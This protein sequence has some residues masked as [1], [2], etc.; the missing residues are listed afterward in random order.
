MVWRWRLRQWHHVVL[1]VLHWLQRYQLGNHPQHYTVHSSHLHGSSDTQR[2][3]GGN[4]GS[5]RLSADVRNF[6]D[7]VGTKK[8]KKEL[9]VYWAFPCRNVLSCRVMWWPNLTA[10]TNIFLT[11]LFWFHDK[12]I[13]I[14]VRETRRN[15]SFVLL[16]NLMQSHLS[17]TS[18]LNHLIYDL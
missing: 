1:C 12:E 6:S 14:S 8:K 10:D 11:L 2:N 5:A 13:H 15:T 3:R 7:S 9:P 18:C 17:F 4:A 16:V